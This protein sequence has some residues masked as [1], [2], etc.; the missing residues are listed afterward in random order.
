M[1]PEPADEDPPRP[2]PILLM[3]RELGIGGCENDLTKIATGI[4]RRRFAPHVGCLYARGMRVP[5]LE[6]AG[7]PIVEL[8]VRGLVSRSWLRGGG[9][10]RRYLRDHGIQLVHTFDAPMDMVAMPMAWAARVPVR[11]KSHLWYRSVLPRS[12][13]LWL[14]ATDRMVDAIVVNSRAAQRELVAGYCVRKERTFLCYNGVDTTRFHPGDRFVETDAGQLTIGT[15]C[16]LR[17][18]KR[19][20]VLVDAFAKAGRNGLD[21]R[22]LVVGSGPMLDELNAQARRLGIVDRTRFEPATSDVA[23]WMRRIDIFVL[24]SMTESFPNALLEAMACGCCVVASDVGGVPELVRP[25]DNGL[26]FPSGSVD[27]LAD[28][29][30][31]LSHDAA[32]RRRLGAGAARTA[33]EEFSVER[34]VRETESLYEVLLARR[35]RVS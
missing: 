5:Q 2:T 33:R 28:A 15:V 32:R 22:L 21:A 31:R 7:V 9:V 24:S 4:D 26:L 27:E 19:V 35:P 3:V 23:A 34:Y 8:P 1:P 16:A 18:E 10:L 20:D 30:R 17:D 25:E 6:A 14:S 13:Q 29:L 12:K 11:I